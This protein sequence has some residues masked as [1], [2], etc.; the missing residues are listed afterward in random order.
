LKAGDKQRLLR[1]ND[2]VSIQIVKSY[3][4][5]HTN[6]LSRNKVA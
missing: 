1:I 5:P 6:R 4:S 3:L 2:V